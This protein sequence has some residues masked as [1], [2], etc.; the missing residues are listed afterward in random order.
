[1]LRPPALPRTAFAR[2]EV[3]RQALE[4]DLRFVITLRN[5]LAHGQ[6]VYPLNETHDEIAQEQMNALRTENVLSLKQ[7]ANL[8]ESI[9]DSIHDLVVS[10]QT[11][12]RDFDGHFRRIEQ[13]RTNIA[14]KSYSDWS[15]QIQLRYKRGQEE[16][17]RRARVGNGP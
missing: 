14:R 2:M 1:E 12:D 9:C 6:W 3:I 17:R 15:R 4:V 16:M 5:K 13:I 11:F 8:V 7:K 10:R